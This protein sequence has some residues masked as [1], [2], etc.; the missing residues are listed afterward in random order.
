LIDSPIGLVDYVIC[1]RAPGRD[2]T[3]HPGLG[4]LL[5]A[6][7]SETDT[8]CSLARS[9]LS[10]F[11][12]QL[13]IVAI[14][15][16]GCSSK[17][18]AKTEVDQYFKANPDAKRATLAKFAGRVSIDGQPPEQGGDYRM[19]I[20]LNDQQKLQKLPLRY[21][22][23]AEDGSFEF[24]TYLAGDG[25]PVGN[26]IVEFVQLHLPRQRQRQGQGVARNYVGP[27]KLK[28]LY[29]DPE[30]NKD[31]PE[32]VVEVKEPGRTDYNFNLSVAGKDAAIPGKFSATTVPGL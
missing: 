1:H 3:L 9:A 19:F 17:P 13:V 29:N 27:D 11:V 4:Q 25:V 24:M 14:A 5:N 2:G 30:K 10:L 7:F 23:V 8:M 12:V 21:M 22:E 18:S 26:Y 6:S 15:L 32:F 16:P 31:N 28:N 20:L